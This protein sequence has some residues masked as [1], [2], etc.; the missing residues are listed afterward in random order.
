[1]LLSHTPKPS[2]AQEKANL[3]AGTHAQACKRASSCANGRILRILCLNNARTQSP[4]DSQTGSCSCPQSNLNQKP[5]CHRTHAHTCAQRRTAPPPPAWRGLAPSP[6]TL[7]LL[8][9]AHFEAFL[10]PAVLAAVPGH[11]VDDA[12]LVPVTRI[13]HVLLDAAS[14]EALGA[15]GKETGY[16]HPQ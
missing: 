1:M 16:T 15:E 10:Q 8:G 4:P 3:G 11:L 9:H 2:K 7:T 5:A 13:H 12:I 14:E 6:R